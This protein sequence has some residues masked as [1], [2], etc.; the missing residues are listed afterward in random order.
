MEPKIDV[1]Q[2]GLKFTV[3]SIL[4]PDHKRIRMQIR[5]DLSEIIDVST[6]STM[7]DGKNV[8]IQIPRVQRRRIDVTNDLANAD[9]LLIGCLPTYERKE[10]LYLLFTAKEIPDID[11]K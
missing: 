11:K 5:M 10:F 1:I 3:R 6:T 8:T 2:E 9:S 7:L 4:S